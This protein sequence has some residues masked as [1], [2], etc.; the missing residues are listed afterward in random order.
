MDAIARHEPVVRNPSANYGLLRPADG[1][2]GEGPQ[3]GSEEEGAKQQVSPRVPPTDEEVIAQ[4]L[5]PLPNVV[6]Q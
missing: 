3:R 1:K 6:G 4:L 2:G 5:S